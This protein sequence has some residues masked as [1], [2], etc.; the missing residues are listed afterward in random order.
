MLRLR[1]EGSPLSMP[2][3]RILLDEFVFLATQS[4]ILSRLKKTF[5]LFEYLRVMPLLNLEE[6]VP[7]EWRESVRGIK[8][9]VRFVNWIAFIGGFSLMLGPVTALLSGS[10][11]TGIRLVLIDPE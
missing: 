10:T 6:M 1:L 9:M 2:I 11:V 3:Q 5:K 4:S 7:E 8:W